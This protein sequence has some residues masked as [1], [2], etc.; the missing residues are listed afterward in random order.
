M[1]YCVYMNSKRYGRLVVRLGAA[2]LFLIFGVWEVTQPSYWIGFIPSFAVG[3]AAP[4]F[5]VMVHGVIL[6]FLG[7]LFLTNSAVRY[8][9][10]AATLVLLSMVVTMYMQT[11]FND[12][13]VRDAVITVFVAS[14]MFED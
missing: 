3:L 13:L 7:F 11:G 8:A 4:N 14:L 10:V 12:L 1:C 6:L 9:A 5:L 2:A